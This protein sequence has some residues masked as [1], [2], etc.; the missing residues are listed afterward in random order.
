VTAV[1][2]FCGPLRDVIHGIKYRRLEFLAGPLI[3]EALAREPLAAF[4]AP[5][6]LVPIPLSVGRRLARGFNQAASLAAAI[7]LATGIPVAH[8]LRRRPSLRAAQARLRRAAR[9]RNLERAFRVP[10]GE[11]A[12]LRGRSIL[13]VD[14]V[15]T[16]GSTL[17]AAAT[18]LA[19]AGASESAAF[20]V[21]ATPQQP[22]FSP[23]VLD[24]ERLD[25][26]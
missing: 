7:S 8:A 23:H 19:F 9:A 22:P 20:A 14:D 11:M 17:R 1:W 24:S 4:P 5:D 21:A 16:T 2:W 15:I 13:L 12:R 6:F 3:D 26:T 25:R 10:K 18:V